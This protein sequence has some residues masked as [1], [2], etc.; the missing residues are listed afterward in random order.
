MP[1][2]RIA[3]LKFVVAS[4]VA[5]AGS[6]ALYQYVDTKL[7]EQRYPPIGKMVYLGSS[8]ANAPA[9]KGYK[10]HMIDLGTE[11][12]GQP[13]IVIEAGSGQSSIDWFLVQPEIAK[14]ARVI[15]Y[16]RA[17]YGWS[18]ASPLP[19]TS[20]NIVQE[21][22]T[23]LHNAN[24]PGPYILVGHSFGGFTVRLF[25]SKYPD[26]VA[27]VVL[28]DALNEKDFHHVPMTSYEKI[29]NYIQR[30]KKIIQS[31]CGTDRI[32]R[33]LDID[34]LQKQLE[35][36]PAFQSA[37]LSFQQQNLAFKLSTKF[38]QARMNEIDNFVE[39]ADQLRAAGGFLGDKPL[40]VITAGKPWPGQENADFNR[41]WPE[42]QAD[43]VT[44]SSRGKQIIAKQSGHM[45]N[46]E[47]PEIIVAAIREMVAS[48]QASSQAI[49]DTVVASAKSNDEL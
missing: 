13:T 33:D 29:W 24:I 12:E 28:V 17:G 26:E 4:L 23:M 11:I 36:Y 7:D 19:R 42:L 5:L 35:N 46:F 9:D 2:L 32:M 3:A 21:L 37:P 48:V 22:H 1:V 30:S 40:T 15:T 14:F 8:Y 39:D 45:V 10:L 38:M 16:D 41:V 20:E 27:G 6:G 34:D 44:K 18:D 49:P 43:L 25:A 31:Y 47:Q